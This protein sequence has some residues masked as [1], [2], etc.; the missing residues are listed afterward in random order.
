MIQKWRSWI[1]KRHPLVQLGKL[2]TPQLDFST[3]LT[4]VAAKCHM[5]GVQLTQIERLGIRSW[6]NRR[7]LGKIPERLLSKAANSCL[8]CKY[9]CLRSDQVIPRRMSQ[10][11]V[12]PAFDGSE[13][14]SIRR[15]SQHLLH[16]VSRPQLPPTIS[17]S[18]ILIPVASQPPPAFARHRARIRESQHHIPSPLS[19]IQYGPTILI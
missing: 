17:I 9:F 3:L 18:L 8:R 11:P 10:Q 6:R 7:N 12:M 1:A 15:S 14:G 19:W 13:L 5:Y 4:E 2:S 16:H